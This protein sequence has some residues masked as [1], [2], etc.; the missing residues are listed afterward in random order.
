MSNLKTHLARGV[1]AAADISDEN[2]TMLIALGEHLD[3]TGLL[4]ECRSHMAATCAAGQQNG[5]A[6][7]K[8]KRQKLKEAKDSGQR[9]GII[10]AWFGWMVVKA[11]VMAF[12]EQFLFG[13]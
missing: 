13:E 7:K 2:Q 3:Q 6:F 1:S 11:V 12:L 8:W 4:A 5:R 10:P 9:M